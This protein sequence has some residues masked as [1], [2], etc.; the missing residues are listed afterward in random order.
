M[1]PV[2]NDLNSAL[3]DMSVLSERVD[4]VAD[5]HTPSTSADAADHRRDIH[6]YALRR[7]E[8]GSVVMGHVSHTSHSSHSSGTSH[9]SHGSHS[10]HTSHVSGSHSSHVSSSSPPATAEHGRPDL[11]IG[12]VGGSLL[13]NNI[14]GSAER[15]TVEQTGTTG[16]TLRWQISVQNDAQVTDRIRVSGVKSADGFTVKYLSADGE[17]VTKAVENG[18]FTTPRLAHGA[19][20]RLTVVVKVTSGAVSNR[21]LTGQVRALSVLSPSRTD[22]VAFVARRG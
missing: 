14:Y 1:G 13:G 16:A 12:E 5:P 7:S 6:L 15:Q 20:Y 3:A 21:P 11:R 10:S 22:T 19:T 9:Y 18:S 2:I 8:T 4:S 17:N